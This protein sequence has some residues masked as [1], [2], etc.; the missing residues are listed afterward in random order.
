MLNMKKKFRYLQVPEIFRFLNDVCGLYF[1]I[2]LAYVGI[3]ISRNLKIHIDF[4][5]PHM[6]PIHQVMLREKLQAT[7]PV[8]FFLKKNIKLTIEDILNLVYNGLALI[9]ILINPFFLL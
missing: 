8:S 6:Q 5:I 9:K 1:I 4:F 7:N 2:N 3:S